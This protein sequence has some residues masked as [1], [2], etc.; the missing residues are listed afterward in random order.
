MIK[1]DAINEGGASSFEDVKQQLEARLKAE[2]ALDLVFERANELEDILGGGASLQEAASAINSSV[3]AIDAIDANGFNIDGGDAAQDIAADSNFLSIGWE[4]DEGEISV[5][6]E[7]GEATFFVV[8]LVEETD[9]TPRALSDVKQRA[10][11]DYRLEQAIIAA[12]ATADTALQA[13]SAFDGIEAV[14]IKRSGIG[15]D[16][17]AASLIAREAFALNQG[18][19]AV[20]ETGDEAI[21]I[22]TTAIEKADASDR[23]ALANQLSASLARTVQSDWTAALSLSLSEDFDLTI[24]EEAVRLLLVGATQ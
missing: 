18:E 13:S 8:E 15:L 24:N 4:L 12:K 3:T 14:T 16:H 11:D 6:A 20:I 5:L 22:K 1:V 2:Q 7:T 17:P 19:T 10:S 23:D 21:I 9:A